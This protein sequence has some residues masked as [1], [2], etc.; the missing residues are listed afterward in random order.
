MFVFLRDSVQSVVP[1]LRDLPE[2]RQNEVIHVL[3]LSLEARDLSDA[4]YEVYNSISRQGRLVHPTDDPAPWYNYPAFTMARTDRPKPQLSMDCSL[5]LS[6]DV[7]GSYRWIHAAYHVDDKTGRTTIFV[8]DQEGDDWMVKVDTDTASGQSWMARAH[9]IWE[10]VSAFAD[11]AA[12]S[13]RLTVCSLGLMVPDELQGEFTSRFMGWRVDVYSMAVYFHRCHPP[14]HH[15]HVRLFFVQR[16]HSQVQ[17]RPIER[18]AW[19]AE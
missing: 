4:A 13:W 15:H 6:Y 9:S 16:A 17:T 12:T 19:Y 11:T 3:P 14:S 8:A 2:T 10:T 5:P 1:L 18:S 7:L